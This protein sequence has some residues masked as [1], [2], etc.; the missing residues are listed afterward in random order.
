MMSDVAILCSVLTKEMSGQL[1]FA[2][3]MT[4]EGSKCYYCPT[5]N[6]DQGAA[7][8]LPY[9]GD[10]EKGDALLLPRSKQHIQ[11]SHAAAA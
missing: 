2:V 3:D 4:N 10:M 7:L 5:S 6:T 1:P 8:Q 11:L 9:Q